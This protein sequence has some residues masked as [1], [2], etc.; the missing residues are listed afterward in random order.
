MR[1]GKEDA[2]PE[3]KFQVAGDSDRNV[4]GALRASATFEIRR[5]GRRVGIVAPPLVPDGERSI[6]FAKNPL[7][8]KRERAQETYRLQERVGAQ[9][10][11]GRRD[12]VAK[13]DKPALSLQGPAESKVFGA[14]ESLVETADCLERCAGAE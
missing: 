5:S 9:L 1:P 12:R 7:G 13:N 6:A 3:V 10:S 14:I 8:V 11:P 4:V 2:L